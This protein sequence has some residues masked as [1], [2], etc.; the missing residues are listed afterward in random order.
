M[1]DWGSSKDRAAKKAKK[2]ESFRQLIPNCIEVSPGM[3]QSIEDDQ[4]L[5]TANGK[6]RV[7]GVWGNGKANL[8]K[9][10][11]KR[12][13]GRNLKSLLRE[14]ASVAASLPL[15]EWERGFCESI[16]KVRKRGRLTEK[17]VNCANRILDKVGEQ[18]CELLFGVKKLGIGVVRPLKNKANEE[19]RGCHDSTA[20]DCDDSEITNRY[21][22]LMQ[23]VL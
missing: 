7:D 6:W 17:Q 4:V 14:E 19:A 3:F 15:T 23:H 11:E 8:K 10:L 20:D 12:R 22:S 21:L 5:F 1:G 16:R 13:G 9:A 2:V 18:H